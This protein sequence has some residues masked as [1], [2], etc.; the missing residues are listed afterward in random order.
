MEDLTDLLLQAMQEMNVPWEIPPK[1][2]LEMQGRFI[3][4]EENKL[5]KVAFPLQEK[6]NNPGGVMQGGILTAAFDNVFGPL[7][8]LAAKQPTTTL[9][10]N[11]TFIR[12]LAPQDHEVIIEGR[13]VEMTKSYQIMDGRAYKPNGKLAATS[14]TRIVILAGR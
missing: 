10:L 11:T 5:L 9:E 7:S 6:F 12:P 4:Y 1:V 8:L 3:E 2:F 13:I 14:Y